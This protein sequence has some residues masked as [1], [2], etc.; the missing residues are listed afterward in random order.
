MRMLTA[1]VRTIVILCTVLAGGPS[2]LAGSSGAAAK[3]ELS[4]RTSAGAE[5]IVSV[6]ASSP[7]SRWDRE[8]A[9]A[10]IAIV[11]LDGHY[12]QDITVDHGS[13]P[14]TYQVFLGPLSAG[15]HSLVVERNDRWS[16]P[17]APLEVQKIAVRSVSSDD[18]EYAAIAHSPILYA[19]ADTLGHFSD[20]PLL[21]W[22]EVFLD[23]GGEEIQYSYV[24]SNEDG[25]TP[26]AALMA[27]WGRTTD[28][29]YAYRIWLDRDGK[30]RRETFQGFSHQ[31][32]PFRGSRDGEHPYILVATPN[33]VFADTG[34]SEMQYHLLPVRADLSRH[35]REE[36]M[37]RFP[38]TYQTM[39]EELKRE[40]KLRPFGQWSLS[41]VSDPRNYLYLELNSRNENAGLN[42]WVK[43]KGSA[44]MYSS[45]GGY[46]QLAIWRSGWFRTTVELP[47][48]TEAGSIQEIGLQCIATPESNSGQP[49]AEPS[50]CQMQDLSKAFLLG[51]DYAPGAG[52]LEIHA[53]M[54]L[55]PG[56]IY[57]LAPNRA[58]AA[59]SP[60]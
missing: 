10:A 57:L 45:D 36:L 21:A 53:P 12:S 51:P 7:G 28:I 40:G 8:G 29:E 42:V 39:A 2:A 22:Y 27:R 43:V 60:G 52:V 59:D 58:D 20:V 4:F 17:Q 26:P 55:K 30:I 47:P 24:F 13:A 23:S 34:A 31:D 15:E 41:T 5:A 50:Q 9:E 32:A 38:W 49:P 14:F 1:S 48:G 46:P 18:P 54:I 6:T 3:A 33:N 11:Y 16:A 44:Q 37:D 19:R 25:G 56:K 35:S